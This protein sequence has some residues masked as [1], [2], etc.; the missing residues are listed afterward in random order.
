MSISPRWRCSVAASGIEYVGDLVGDFADRDE[1]VQGVVETEVE[2][3]GFEIQAARG[4][5]ADGDAEAER[6]DTGCGLRKWEEGGTGAVAVAGLKHS[7]NRGPCGDSGFA[8][9]SLDTGEVVAA[10]DDRKWFGGRTCEMGKPEHV[11]K[12]RGPIGSSEE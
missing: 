1:V 5:E 8:C 7:G 6:I 4:R 11:A 9:S 3:F 2:K 12:L 10:Q